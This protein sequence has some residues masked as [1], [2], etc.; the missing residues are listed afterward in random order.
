MAA[1]AYH[2]ESVICGHHIYKSIWSLEIGEVLP[3]KH[4]RNNNKD[5]YVINE[6]NDDTIVGH[7]IVK[8]L[9]Y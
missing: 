1:G 4:K 2:W 3:C 6:L 7:V 9:A 8:C 5:P